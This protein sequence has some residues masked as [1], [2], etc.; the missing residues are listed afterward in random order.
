MENI[1]LM[2]YLTDLMER[3]RKCLELAGYRVTCAMS[4]SEVLRLIEESM[5]E[6]VVLGHGVPEDERNQIARR[7]K[8]VSPAAKLVMLY[9]SSIKNAE[10]ADALIHTTLDPADLV[11]TID[12]LTDKLSRR[13]SG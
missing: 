8:Q 3:R 7:I 11:R 9:L 2:G 1:L 13:M 12:D 4:F 5:F 10:L 6:V